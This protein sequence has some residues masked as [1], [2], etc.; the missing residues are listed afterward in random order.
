MAQ[1]IRPGA[2]VLFGG[3]P[4]TFHMKIASSPMAAIEALQLD[5]AYVAVAKSLGL[6]TQSYMALS[7]A[8]TLDAQAG[9]ETFGSA[10]LAALAGVNSVSG[11]GMLDF[12]LVFSL[13]KLVFDDAMCGQVL[14]FVRS[15]RELDDLPVAGLI[16]QL[17]ADQHL[18]MAPHTLEHWPSE[19]HLPSSL[20][21]RDNREAW[22]RAG[23][24]EIDARAVDEVDRRLASYHQLETDPAIEAELQRIIRSGLK[25][26]DELPLVPPAPEPVAAPSGAGRRHNRRREQAPSDAVD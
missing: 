19:L 26:Q 22:T 16:D 4:A 11:P 24:K 5:V 21:D 25:D 1:V 12:L 20:I 14:H 18:I 17:M 8:K 23:A 13:P 9:A 15:V 6:P 10:L 2:P 7:D 3:A